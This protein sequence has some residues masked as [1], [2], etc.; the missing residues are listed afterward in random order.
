MSRH[1]Q[2]GLDERHRIAAA[3]LYWQAFG[4]KLNAVMGPKPRALAYLNRV[5]RLDLCISVLEADQLLGIVGLQSPS[6]SFAG[7]SAADFRAI[8]GQARGM[9]RMP[10]MIWVGGKPVADNTLMIDGFSVALPAR[11][12]GI[13]GALLHEVLAHAR[14]IGFQSVQL[15]VIDSNWRAKAFYTRHGFST[16][17][18]RSIWPLGPLFGFQSVLRMARHLE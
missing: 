9:L 16:Q 6:G 1:I 17:S 15:D 12:Q 7:G 3:D 18:R 4:S 10:A 13:G 2:H 5:M 14:N 11:G 8:Y